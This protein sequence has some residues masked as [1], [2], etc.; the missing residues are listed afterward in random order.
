MITMKK[1]KQIELDISESKENN[2]RVKTIGIIL[3]IITLYT[4]FASLTGEDIISNLYLKNDT[5][6]D[7]Y[8]HL[9][10]S[11][12]AVNVYTYSY[13]VAFPPL[14]YIFY[15]ILSFF[16]PEEI[17][18]VRTYI[19]LCDEAIMLYALYSLAVAVAL[20]YTLQK[21]IKSKNKNIF[22][23]AILFSGSLIYA[24]Q[25][26]NSVI[27][28]LILVLS[29]FYNYYEKKTKHSKNLAYLFLSL[30][31]CCKIYP[32]FFG[33]FLL[34]EK[35]Y[36]GIIKCVILT[37]LLFFIPFIFF[38]GYEGLLQMISNLTVLSSNDSLD[39]G[40][41]VIALLYNNGW[42]GLIPIVKFISIIA[43]FISPFVI[44]EKWKLALIICCCFMTIQDWCGYYVT[45]YFIIPLVLY[46]NESK[47]NRLD[48]VYAFFSILIISTAICFYAP[49]G[50][51]SYIVCLLFIILLIELII[52]I[53]LIIKEK[54]PYILKTKKEIKG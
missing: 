42:N 25:R 7:F 14:M 28:A 40:S 32:V 20:I 27:I 3:L 33:V 48:E 30:A 1:K 17:I 23:T 38:G 26:G 15:Y 43:L 53:I 44:K 29:F 52:K 39:G 2:S 13:N 37:S 12:Y 31:V 10:Y 21:L 46:L 22:I 50:N 36:K 6:A 24:Y 16:I 54:L 5:F 8:N 18:N 4:I 11:R 34:K 41:G 49:I 19:P 35:D 9:F 47:K 45:S 51:Q